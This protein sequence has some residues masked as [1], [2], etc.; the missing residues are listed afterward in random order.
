MT[1]YLKITF[2]T[3]TIWILASL[4]NGLLCATYQSVLNG[5]PGQIILQAIVN[6]FVSL[7]FS[8]PAFFIFWIIL[9]I[10]VE[11]KVYERHLFRVALSAGLILS[12]ATALMVSNLVAVSPT[13]KYAIIPFA[14]LS[15][16]ISIMM[17]FNYF[18][19][20]NKQVQ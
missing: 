9:L 12:A 2:R 7:F 18:K 17:H 16:I 6:S 11:D 4:I 19:K 20:L 1:L 5:L 13:D 3:F 14:I 10:K 8:A 15:S